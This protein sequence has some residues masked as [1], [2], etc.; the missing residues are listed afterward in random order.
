MSRY[1]EITRPIY[2]CGMRIG[3]TTEYK[4]R[5]I[6]RRTDIFICPRSGVREISKTEYE[7]NA[8]G[9]R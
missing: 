2:S 7:D 4:I 5:D 1:F 8:K 3:E 6:P 9:E